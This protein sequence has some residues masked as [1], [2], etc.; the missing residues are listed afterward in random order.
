MGGAMTLDNAIDILR[1]LRAIYA[2]ITVI[3]TITLILRSLT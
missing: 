2:A 1:R 3:M